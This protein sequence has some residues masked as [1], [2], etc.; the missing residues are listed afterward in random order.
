MSLA[1]NR[2]TLQERAQMLFAVRSFFAKRNVLEADTPIL[3]PYAPIDAYID[4][5]EVN[6]G[7]GKWGYLHTSP[8]YGLKKLLAKE[9]IDLYQL[10]HVFRC[11][12]QSPLHSAEFTMIE[13]YRVEKTLSFLIE[14]T[15]E[16]MKLFLGDLPYET[17]TYKEA[18]ETYAKVDPFKED[19]TPHVLSFSADAANW[20]LDTKR[21]LLFS[22]LVEP[23]LGK[24][25][26]TVITDYPAS[27]AA[28]A[29]IEIEEGLAVAKRF[30]VY[31]AGVELA[32]GFD[33]LKDPLEQKNRLDA[34]NRK[35]VA[36]GKKA[37]PIDKE[38]LD[39]LSTLPSCVGVAVGFDRLMK[40]STLQ[41]ISNHL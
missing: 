3:S 23:H 35:R 8:E 31:F 27:Q 38:F 11:D 18:M 32:N 25:G 28:L 24:N 26:L 14:E 34:E 10:C 6:M 40:L 39:A 7:H 21:D 37:L 29:K 15:C 12:E 30:E 13:W 19:L 20:D 36:L 5:M 9:P 2:G 33:E 22:H 41:I 4:V 17:L 1:S 16:L